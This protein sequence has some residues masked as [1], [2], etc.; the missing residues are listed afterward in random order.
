VV[1]DQGKPPQHK[2]KY[3]LSLKQSVT[4]PE[5]DTSP[6]QGKPF[7]PPLDM[8]KIEDLLRAT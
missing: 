8:S 5:Q 4:V 1:S 2:P 7:V 3:S 6:K